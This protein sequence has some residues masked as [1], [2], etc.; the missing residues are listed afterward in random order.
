MQNLPSI[1]EYIIA[2][3]IIIFCL[4][5]GIVFKR[6]TV[7]WLLRVTSKTAWKGDEVIVNA[8]RGVFTFLF[9][10]A[11]LYAAAIY[12]P[13]FGLFSKETVFMVLHILATFCFTLIISRII[14]GWMVLN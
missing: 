14:T 4:F 9:L 11:G 12:M 7:K 13:G 5:L 3:A 2:G 1:K 8:S 6:I 10:L